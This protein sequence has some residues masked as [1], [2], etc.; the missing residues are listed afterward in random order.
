MKQAG[1]G[2]NLMRTILLPFS[3]PPSDDAHHRGSINM[4]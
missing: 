3:Q 1:L 2:S 4:A